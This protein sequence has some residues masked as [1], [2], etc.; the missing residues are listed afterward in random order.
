MFKK[1]KVRGL[2]EL[3]GS[4]T[5]SCVLNGSEVRNFRVDL[6]QETGGSQVG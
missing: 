6:K 1:T 3:L 2:P 5:I 4:T